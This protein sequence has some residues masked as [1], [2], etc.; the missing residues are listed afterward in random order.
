MKKLHVVFCILGSLFL[1]DSLLGQ[2]YR[3]AEISLDSVAAF[4]LDN[5]LQVAVIEDP[6]LPTVSL[7]LF[8]NADSVYLNSVT[9][10]VVRYLRD[11]GR[12]SLWRESLDRLGI[13]MVSAPESLTLEA[14][15]NRKDTLLGI[16]KHSVSQVVFNPKLVDS[17]RTEISR[18]RELALPGPAGTANQVS[19]RL[20]AGPAPADTLKADS[21]NCTRYY[22]RAYGPEGSLLVVIGDVSADTLR[23]VLPVKLKEWKLRGELPASH[24]DSLTRPN[25]PPCKVYM[26][27][28]ED[29][30]D[31]YLKMMIP[32]VDRDSVP[33][34]HQFELL[35]LLLGGHPQSR[36]NQNLRIKHGFSYG[37]VSDI[38]H[39]SPFNYLTIQGGVGKT[40]ADS[41]IWQIFYEINQLRQTA[42]ND[43]QIRFGKKMLQSRF[44]QQAGQPL[45]IADLVWRQL[46][47]S[48]P[49]GY[50]AHYRDSI[51]QTNAR[52]LLQTAAA[53][54]D[55][56]HALVVVVGDRHTLSRGVQY[57]G[58]DSTI[59]YLDPQGNKLD[60]SRLT[61]MPDLTA[62]QV[63][64]RYL[65]TIS[66]SGSIDSLHSIDARWQARFSES[67]LDMVIKAKKPGRLLME[68]STDGFLVNA[69]KL[70]G[71]TIQLQDRVIL[72]DSLYREQLR[73]QAAIIPEVLYKNVE[74]KLQLAGSEFVGKERAYRIRV[75]FAGEAWDEFYSMDSGLKIASGREM[76]WQGE[77][78][79]LNQ[80]FGDYREVDGVMLPHETQLEGLFPWPVTFRLTSVSLNSQL[81]DTVF[82]IE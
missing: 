52:Q 11:A 36:L 49:T 67:S 70:N 10:L 48:W 27:H 4:R 15:T 39:G 78:K 50:F 3:R 58:A 43:R 80:H 51:R 6:N 12:D 82:Q 5:G 72:S 22:R 14:L 56:S 8:L 25:F 13:S 69:T 45:N 57:I 26:V 81:D 46:R 75:E 41:A 21:I 37:V 62:E 31:P 16:L 44:A 23:R 35:S 61:I 33:K 53:Y 79:T 17:L 40:S 19:R 24:V 32:F 77:R 65:D 54:L 29:A 74:Y 63:I 60:Y 64:A 9:E 71:D 7:K 47:S 55:P 59:H 30:G 73:T 68:I 28:R 66:V 1:W 18:E 34:D 42:L 38:E 2:N 76:E 20:V